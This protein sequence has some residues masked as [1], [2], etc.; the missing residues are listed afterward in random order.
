L[1]GIEIIRTRKGRA[2]YHPSTGDVH[3]RP[4]AN[5]ARFSE[6]LQGLLEGG[7]GL[8]EMGGVALALA[9]ALERAAQVVLSP[10]PL[11]RDTL[12]GELLQSLL[13]GG[14]GLGEMG[15]AALALA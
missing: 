12:A 2:S 5:P 13:E 6:L 14:D 1:C 10:S 9:E 7:D 11:Q 15:G 3:Q 4:P 8:G